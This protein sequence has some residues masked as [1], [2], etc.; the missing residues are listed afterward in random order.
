MKRFIMHS[1]LKPEKVQEYVELHAKPWP[2]L[3]ELIGQCNIHNYSISIMGT[4]LYTYYEYTG[5]DYEADMAV[6]DNSAIMQEWWKHSKPCFLHHAE[7]K[8]YDDLREI[9]YCP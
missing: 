1:D 9:F 2:E 5:S 4:Q 8:Y 7:G 3:L 6:M